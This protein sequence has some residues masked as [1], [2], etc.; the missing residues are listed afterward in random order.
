[1]S[2]Y[3]RVDWQALNGAR[4]KLRQLTIQLEKGERP[5]DDMLHPA[6]KLQQFLREALP[7]AW[8]AAEDKAPD[9]PPVP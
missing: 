4:K 3:T 9:F 2:D 6:W 7:D 5:A 1:V 8:D